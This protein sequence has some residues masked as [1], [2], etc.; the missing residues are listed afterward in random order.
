MDSWYKRASSQ[1]YYLGNCV[2]LPE[3]FISF[4]VDNAQKISYREIRKAIPDIEEHNPGGP[5][6]KMSK[7]WAVSFWKSR[8][9]S[10]VGLYFF[11]HSSIEYVFA[12]EGSNLDVAKEDKLAGKML[13]G[14]DVDKNEGDE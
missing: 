11:D 12:P 6:P 13:W 8:S 7:D 14:D 3:D 2:G 4:I 1:F 10:G 5:I 9:P